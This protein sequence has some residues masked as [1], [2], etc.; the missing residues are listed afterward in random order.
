MKIVFISFKFNICIY[1][2]KNNKAKLIIQE[3]AGEIDP[4]GS[5]TAAIKLNAVTKILDVLNAPT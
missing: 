2:G 3:H 1:I 5:T 4:N